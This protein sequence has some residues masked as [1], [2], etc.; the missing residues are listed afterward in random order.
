MD[1]VE[2]LRGCQRRNF[3]WRKGGNGSC[4]GSQ[5]AKKEQNNNFKKMETL[6]VC[7]Y[8]DQMKEGSP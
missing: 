2:P 8:K 4:Q 3:F 6:S 1:L 5:A 7:L